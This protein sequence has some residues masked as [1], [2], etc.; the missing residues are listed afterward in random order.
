MVKSS[1]ISH[2]VDELPMIEELLEQILPSEL[3]SVLKHLNDAQIMLNDLVA[4]AFYLDGFRTG[5]L[6]IL[7]IHDHASESLKPIGA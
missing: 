2:A 6:L 4:D 7:T 5:A 1:E 3:Q